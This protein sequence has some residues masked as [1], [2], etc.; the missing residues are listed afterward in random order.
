MSKSRSRFALDYDD[1][2][3]QKRMQAEMLI[4]GLIEEHWS[5]KELSALGCELKRRAQ[6][7]RHLQ[8]LERIGMDSRPVIMEPESIEVK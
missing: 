1:L 2:K 7:I 3:P 5:V 6:Q 8:E 4:R